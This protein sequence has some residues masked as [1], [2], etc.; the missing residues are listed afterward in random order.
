M[1]HTVRTL[2]AAAVACL[3]AGGV[4]GC[5]AAEEDT[6]TLALSTQ[7]NPFFVQVRDGALER[8]A[9]LGV[10]LGVQDA[11]DDALKQA[12]QLNTAVAT[13]ADVVLV[14]PVDS[15]AVGNSVEALNDAGIPVVALD[16]TANSGRL[17]SYVA[18]DN[19]SGG[20]QAADAL[21]EAIGGRGKVIVLQGIPGSS[22]S[23]DRGQGFRERIA[24]YPDIEIVAQQTAGFDRTKGLDVATNLLQAN[25]DV[26]GIFAENDEMALGAIE[27][28]GARAG[29]EVSI[30]GFDGTS[31]GLAAVDAG[32]MTATIAQQ[33]RELGAVAVE[34]AQ[35]LLRGDT[36]AEVVPVP[37]VSVTKKNVGE[38]L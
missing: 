11:G 20:R 19:V 8:A 33:P 2:C 21:A 25:P 28:V 38:Y 34:Q 35:A 15:D 6:V 5:A 32:T 12:D 36:V 4:A 10:D 30:V 24:E 14:N 29:K 26:V 9:E 7:T 1:N 23:R 16:R 22:S 31:E 37:V 27:A 13:D 17:T 18:S 3:L